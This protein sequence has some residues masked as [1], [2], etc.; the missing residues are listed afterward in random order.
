MEE[1]DSNREPG[2]LPTTLVTQLAPPL[3]HQG[4]AHLNKRDLL[5]FRQGLVVHLV[6]A[7]LGKAEGELW[8]VQHDV[9]P[10]TYSARA[11]AP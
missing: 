1:T 11:P 6:G 4:N 8:V 5:G 3:L 9:E 7:T 2:I 10:S